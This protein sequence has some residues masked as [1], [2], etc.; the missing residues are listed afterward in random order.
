MVE[1]PHRAGLAAGLRAAVARVVVDRTGGLGRAVHEQRP[2]ADARS[3]LRRDDDVV[4]ADAS[5]AGQ[6]GRV[7]QEDP[8]AL[9]EVGRPVALDRE[10]LLEPGRELLGDAD[11]D[12]VAGRA[13]AVVPVELRLD[14][15]GGRPRSRRRRPR[16]RATRPRGAGPPWARPAS[17]PRG[18]CRS[19]D[20][21]G[22]KATPSGPRRR[23]PRRRTRRATWPSQRSCPSAPTGT[24]ASRS[25]LPAR[26][27]ER[28]TGRPRRG[29]AA[30]SAPAGRPASKGCCHPRSSA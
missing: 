28:R 2:P 6:R 16:R 27:A 18:P 11:E 15:Q 22:A 7:L 19:S 21:C 13:L 3:V 24:A 12:A 30:R 17:A 10:R 26:A 8:G 1:S 14:R 20:R 5:E 25:L 29:R 23:L 4:L 9:D